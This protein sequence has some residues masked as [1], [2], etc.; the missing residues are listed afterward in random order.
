MLVGQDTFLSHSV[1]VYQAVEKEFELP[2]DLTESRTQ[3]YLWKEEQ[4]QAHIQ[5]TNTRLKNIYISHMY[6]CIY[7]YIYEKA[8]RYMVIKPCFPLWELDTIS[9]CE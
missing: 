7:M 4:P 1:C 3:Y 5:K 9:G 8:V 6:L 2:I